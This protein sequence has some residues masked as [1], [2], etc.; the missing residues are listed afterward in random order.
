MADLFSPL[1]LQAEVDR[2]MKTVPEGRRIAVLG[3]AS[4]D[5]QWRV[6]ARAALGDDGHWHIEG[7]VSGH[8]GHDLAAQVSVLASW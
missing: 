6:T 1:K 7:A 2:L 3:I 8:G 4:A 5:G